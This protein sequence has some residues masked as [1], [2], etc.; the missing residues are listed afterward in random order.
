[1]TPAPSLEG[2]IRW[3]V[4][5][6]PSLYRGADY[7][8]SRMP[9]LNHLFL[10]IG[11]GYEWDTKRGILVDR[12]G[13]L[14]QHVPLSQ[15]FFDRN[16]YAIIY[17][18][19]A[20][21]AKARKKPDYYYLTE[22]EDPNLIF[23]AQDDQSA[24]YWFRRFERD[25]GYTSSHPY[26]AHIR[27]ERGTPYP[28]SKY[29]ALTEILQGHTTTPGERPVSFKADPSWVEGALE[30]ARWA[31][32]YYH[33]RERYKDNQYYSDNVQRQMNID[34]TLYAQ[35]S[36]PEPHW[37]KDIGQRTIAQYAKEL[38]YHHLNEQ[39]RILNRFVNKFARQED[40]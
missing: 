30:V 23:E 5:N 40:K 6:Y 20:R 14:H 9:V 3:V 2:H 25:R 31:L 36:A 35:G 32:A 16:L 8:S 1:M 10:V 13:L 26:H 34:L 24:M 29:S 15:G 11:N 33:D 38:W 7:S 27:G 17:L 12:S 39:L 19:D 22:T 28:I 18:D 37:H 21:W 4:H